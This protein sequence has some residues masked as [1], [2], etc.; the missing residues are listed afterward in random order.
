MGVMGVTMPL[1]LIVLFG[2]SW[3]DTAASCPR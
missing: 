2:V 1:I 3:F